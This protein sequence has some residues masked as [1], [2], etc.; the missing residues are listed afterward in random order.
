[1]LKAKFFEKRE[2]YLL[3]ILEVVDDEDTLF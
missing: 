3:V 1:V 2:N